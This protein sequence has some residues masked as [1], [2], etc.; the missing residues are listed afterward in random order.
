MGAGSGSGG[1][2]GSGGAVGSAVGSGC[3]VGSEVGISSAVGAGSG[4]LQA[5][6]SVVSSSRNTSVRIRFRF[7]IGLR[8][9]EQ[10]DGSVNGGLGQVGA[11]N[12]AGSRGRSANEAL[13]RMRK[14]VRSGTDPWEPARLQR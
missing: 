7:I 9:G 3:A 10:E 12:L 2:V 14:A 13:L 8:V 1:V 11:I 6:S 5:A 4:W